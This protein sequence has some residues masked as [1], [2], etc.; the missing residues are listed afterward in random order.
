MDLESVIVGHTQIQEAIGGAHHEAVLQKTESVFTE[1]AG[2]D[3]ITA[4]TLMIA[5]GAALKAL[6]LEETSPTV[7]SSAKH[8]AASLLQ[9]VI[10]EEAVK[11][12]K[13]QPLPNGL[14]LEVKFDE[15]DWLGW[16]GS[17]FNWSER[18]FKGKFDLPP[19]QATRTIP[20]DFSMALLADWGTG[21]YGAPD[22]TKSIAKASYQILMHLGDVYYAGTNGEEQS[23]FLKY[24]PKMQGAQNYALNSNHEMY[25][26]GHGYMEVLLKDERFK[27]WQTS[28]YF[29]LQNDNFLIVGLDTAYEEHS[30]TT[31]EK[32]WLE[33]LVANAGS[34]KVILF[35]H[36][37]PYSAFEKDNAA[38]E[39]LLSLVSPLLAQRKIFA[40]YWGHEHRCIIYNL[41]PNFGLYGRCLGHGG[42]PQFRASN[43]GVPSNCPPKSTM[44]KLAAHGGPSSLFL[45]GPNPYIKG[46]EKDYSPNGYMTLG[47]TGGKIHET[48]C[49][50]DG[51]IV[52]ENDL[53]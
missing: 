13:I 46:Q 40:W 14:G 11:A 29:A 9:S 51:A 24:W 19:V 22:C 44:V 32:S 34:K 1:A 12:G 47:F 7:L 20:N 25:T 26:G 48:V 6:Q 18:L 33:G 15:E 10:A 52:W 2:G 37:Q 23:R 39:H 3:Q 36:H 27:N 53:Q 45:D 28:N 38:G 35:S 41:H 42:Y 8:K 43:P 17:F 49:D 31:V 16:A 21:L 30:L 50:P 4:A 5:F